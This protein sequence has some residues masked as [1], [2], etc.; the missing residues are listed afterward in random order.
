MWLREGFR[1]WQGTGLAGSIGPRPYADA[2]DGMTP[3]NSGNT[4]ST[5]LPYDC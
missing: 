5:P 1:V 3:A 4:N 2:Y